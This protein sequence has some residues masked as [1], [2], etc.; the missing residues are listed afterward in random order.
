MVMDN[1]IYLS[2]PYLDGNEEK[3]IIDAV[4]T[5]SIAMGKY[6]TLFEE[7]VSNITGLKNSVAVASGTSGM[8]LALKYLGVTKGDLVLCSSLTF[9]ASCNPVVYLGAEPVFIDSEYETWNMSSIALEK[10]FISLKKENKIPKAVII[11]NLYGQSADMDKLLPICEEYG[12]PVIEDAAESI[13]ALYKDKPSGSF[14][15]INIFSFNG[16][17]IVTS[18]GGGMLV[19]NDKA[20]IDKCRFWA[21]QSREN[22]IHYEHREIGYNYRINNISAALG[23]A[24]LEKLEEKILRKKQIFINYKNEINRL[25]NTEMMPVP[26]YSEPNYWLSVM[27]FKGIESITPR[28]MFY[29]LKEENIESRPVWKP[30][31]LQPLYKGVRFFSHYDNK[32]VADDLYENGLCLPSGAGLTDNEQEKVIDSIMKAF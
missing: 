11:V 31:H 7:T 20:A 17:K 32:A 13:G 14:G 29:K 21:N 3:Y 4:S 5:N 1:K 24:Q 30:M 19:S 16:N 22:E 2:A 6:I 10:A 25:K 18:A 23:V 28:Q 26:E 15:K 9:A 12:V 27:L 8:H